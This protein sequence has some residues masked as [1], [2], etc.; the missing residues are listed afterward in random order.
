MIFGGCN[1]LSKSAIEQLVTGHSDSI[2][3]AQRD[4][5][6]ETSRQTRN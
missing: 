3:A 4:S 1:E 2:M 6:P 5:I